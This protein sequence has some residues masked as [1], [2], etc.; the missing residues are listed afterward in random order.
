VFCPRCGDESPD[1]VRYCS[2]CGAE[3]P[4]PDDSRPQ[5]GAGR[6]A[7]AVDR[8]QRLVGRTRRERVVSG[9]IAALLVVAFIGLLA[10]DPAE[11]EEV[12][13]AREALDGAC[14]AAKAQVVEAA[15][16]LTGQGGPE[17]YALRV[18]VTMMDLREAAAASGL[19]GTEEL[20][21]AAFRAAVAAGR[22]GRLAREEGPG[23]TLAEAVQQSADALDGLSAPTDDLGLTA[24]AAASIDTVD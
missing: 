9:L 11:D 17:E 23:P 21:T 19:T 7:R 4:R 18:V 22:V 1:G 24:C 14:V 16:E 3:L 15:N 5:A 12:V 13:A 10:L 20:R 2:S 8:L 6:R